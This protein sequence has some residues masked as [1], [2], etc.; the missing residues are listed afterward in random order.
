MVPWR[1]VTKHYRYRGISGEIRDLAA[2]R[3]FEHALVFVQAEANKRDFAAA[4][5]FNP[6][7]LDDPATIYALDAGFDHRAAVVAYFPDRPVWVVGR[8]RPGAP[9]DVVAGP[10]APG[11]VPR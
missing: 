5:N 4:F 7:T 2:S 8:P 6:P 11:T 1:A 9:I 3:H 10:L